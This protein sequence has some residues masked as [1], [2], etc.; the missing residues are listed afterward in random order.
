MK[1]CARPALPPRSIP[2]IQRHFQ[3]CSKYPGNWWHA[4]RTLSRMVA[5][6]SNRISGEN[7][8]AVSISG[9]S[10]V[11]VSSVTMYRART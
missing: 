2:L 4:G 3:C 11:L 6:N 5:V 10:S 9:E 8:V 1:R 7:S